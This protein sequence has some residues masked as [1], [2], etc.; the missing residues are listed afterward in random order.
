MRKPS[1]LKIESIK[2]KNV[3]FSRADRRAKVVNPII[4]NGDKLK[5]KRNI[6]TIASL[7]DNAEISIKQKKMETMIIITF[8]KSESNPQLKV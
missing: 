3:L 5:I 4:R 1:K 7:S 8:I 2:I 6:N